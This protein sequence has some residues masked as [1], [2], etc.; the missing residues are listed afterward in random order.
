MFRTRFPPRKNYPRSDQRSDVHFR[1]LPLRALWLKPSVPTWLGFLFFFLTG[2]RAVEMP[3]DPKGKWRDRTL[4]ESPVLALAEISSWDTISSPA[5]ARGIDSTL[6][7]IAVMKQC[8]HS[9]DKQQLCEHFR[10][11]KKKKKKSSL[12]SM[13]P[14]SHDAPFYRQ[15]RKT[16]TGTFS[17]ESEAKLT[18][19]TPSKKM[20]G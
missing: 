4:M 1:S 17:R 14:Q 11:G 9:P 7:P 10:E 19:H 8:G 13:P 16:T 15:C 3:P 12:T 18:P 20:P 5:A 6:V 2:W